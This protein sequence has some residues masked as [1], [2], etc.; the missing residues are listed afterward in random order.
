MASWS[1]E[2]DMPMKTVM[3]AS[4]G[5]R[6]TA[7]SVSGIAGLMGKQRVFKSG[8]KAIFYSGWMKMAAQ[9][10]PPLSFHQNYD[11]EQFTPKTGTTKGFQLDLR[12]LSKFCN[13]Q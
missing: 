11:F 3:R 8:L 12:H 4:G 5:S 9:S 6:A 7:G 13:Q 10:I 2:R 1:V